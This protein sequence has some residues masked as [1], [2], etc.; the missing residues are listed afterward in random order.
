MLSFYL[1][2]FLRYEEIWLL[3]PP[4]LKMADIDIGEGHM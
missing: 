3:K 2:Y 1:V 4:S